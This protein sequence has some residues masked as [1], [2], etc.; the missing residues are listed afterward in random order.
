MTP[1][2]AT[3]AKLSEAMEK[4]MEATTRFAWRVR[5]G[6]VGRLITPITH[7]VTLLIPPITYLLSL[8]DP[9][10]RGYMRPPSLLTS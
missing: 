10:S 4:Q 7:T 9:S 1:W 8:P 5:G 6:V 2:L 3:C